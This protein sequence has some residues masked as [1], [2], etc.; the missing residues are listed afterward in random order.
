MM[1]LA[2]GCRIRALAPPPECIAQDGTKHA[3]LNYKVDFPRSGKH[4][5]PMIAHPVSTRLDRL[6]G[7]AIGSFAGMCVPSSG[8]GTRP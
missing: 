1:R 4:S 7:K 3:G 5:Q 6:S 2:A 8:S